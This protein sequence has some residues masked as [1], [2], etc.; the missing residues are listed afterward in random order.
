MAGIE[1]PRRARRRFKQ[2]YLTELHKAAFQGSTERT[3]AILSRGSIDIDG[4]DLELGFSALMVAAG[5]G[6]ARVVQILLD[7]GADV[8]IVSPGGCTAVLL[9]AEQG[10]VAATTML[11]KAG[12]DLEVTDNEGFTPLHLAAHSGDWGMIRVL[13]QGGANVDRRFAKDRQTALHRCANLGHADATR[14]LLRGK[15]DAMMTTPPADGLKFVALELASTSGHSAVVRELIQHVGIKGC[16]G[17]SRGVLA[18]RGATQVRRLDIMAMLTEAGV[19]DTGEALT[20]AAC[21]AHEACAKFLLQQHRARNPA[22]ARAYLET[23]DEAG[24]TPLFCCIAFC[25]STRMVRLLI[26]A[27]ADTYSAV[28]IA[29]PVGG[30]GFN[31]TPLGWTKLHLEVIKTVNG[32][33]ATDKQL[34]T[35][36]AIRRLLLRV[37]AVHAVSWLWPGGVPFV[38]RAAAQG[39]GGI[40]STTTPPVATPLTAMLPVLRERASRRGVLLAAQSRLVVGVVENCHVNASLKAIGFALIKVLN[41]FLCFYNVAELVVSAAAAAAAASSFVQ[42]APLRVLTAAAAVATDF[43]GMFSELGSWPRSRC[44]CHSRC[45]AVVPRSTSGCTNLLV[46]CKFGAEPC[47]RDN[48][49]WDRHD[50]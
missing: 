25:P 47:A 36:R 13:V 29:D 28:R 4:V 39:S 48:L 2:Q 46:C 8:S 15:A 40:N 14:E 5:A 12:A 38:L 1:G 50:R 37:A 7:H 32:K 16:G 17:A 34:D 35:L 49:L 6:H 43:S 24:R 23:R 45:P 30:M 42:M 27:G 11:I 26:D 19:V 10:H 44:P 41:A 9:A 22:G 3:T 20:M 21:Y 18:L 31:N 33:P